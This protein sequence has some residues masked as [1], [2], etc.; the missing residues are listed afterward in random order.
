MHR[1]LKLLKA[2]LHNRSCVMDI[3]EMLEPELVKFSFKSDT[4]EEAIEKIVDLMNENGYL[5]DKEQYLK[6]VYAREA[7]TATGMGMGLAIPHA[8]SAGVKKTCFSLIH[9]EKKIKWESLDDQ[10]VEF[11]IM[12]AVPKDENSEFLSLLS[13]LSMKL[14]DD[15]FRE[16]LY[17]AQTIEDVYQ[18]FE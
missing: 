7:E 9:L 1:A 8:R 10:P 11:I 16:N 17:A 2:F 15:E 6:D 13:G 5:S 14:V 4:K 3:K 18:I 12:L